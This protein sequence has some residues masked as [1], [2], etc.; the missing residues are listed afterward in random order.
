MHEFSLVQ[1]LLGQVGALR[2]DQQAERVVTVRVSVGEFSGVEPELFR[3]AYEM[4]IEDTPLR[5]AELQLNRVPLEAHCNHCE[6]EFAVARFRFVCP[7]CNSR[8]L[9]IL[10]GEDLVL[11][12]ITVEQM[13]DVSVDSY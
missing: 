2:R 3:A 7:E 10:R 1:S 11:E 13:E 9:E 8:D 4:L 5:G 12:S 6:R